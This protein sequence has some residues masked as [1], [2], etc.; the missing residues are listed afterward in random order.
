ML[1][2]SIYSQL[3]EKMYE[4]EKNYMFLKLVL[5]LLQKQII[6]VYEGS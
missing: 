6:F 1:V 3:R 5:K 2:D 4:F